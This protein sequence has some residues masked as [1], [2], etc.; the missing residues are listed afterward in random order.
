MANDFD[1]VGGTLS[2]TTTSVTS[3]QGVTVTIDAAT[4]LY[5]YTPEADYVGKDSFVYSIISTSGVSCDSEVTITVND[6]EN[7]T[8]ATDDAYNALAG[9]TITGNVLFNDNDAQGDVQTVTSTT[10][11]SL[12]GINVTINAT[13][14]AFS[15]TPSSSAVTSD[16]FVYAITDDAV[17]PRFAATDTATVYLTFNRPNLS[18]IHI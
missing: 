6:C 13:T 15:Y 5:S 7:N 9:I 4:G 11:T 8:S 3:S 16:Q 1:P 17:A 10:V 2:V 14:G 18:L 12:L